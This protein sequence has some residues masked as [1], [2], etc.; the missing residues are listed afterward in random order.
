[1][2]IAALLTV[3]GITPLPNS[4]AHNDYVHA[5]PL[6]DAL[7]A[8]FCSI[9]ADIFLQD[10]KLL[11]G[12]S[13]KELDA[14]R[15]LESLY[16]GPLAQRARSN[17]GWIY[18]PD[19]PVQLLI[20]IKADGEA[21]YE[22]LRPMLERYSA[23]LTRWDGERLVPSAV[24]VVISGDRPFEKIAKSS[25]RYCAIDGRA[26]DL[27]QNPSPRLV[28]LISENWLGQFKW[29]GVRSMPSDQR[30]RLREFVAKAH[31]QGRKVRFWATP[32]TP[33][34]WKELWAAKVDYIGADRFDDLRRFLLEQRPRP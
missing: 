26:I 3:V 13:R 24:S 20:D 31:G 6:L 22:V 4:H 15:T 16:L 29:L 33:D 9:E 18:R 30:T 12:H 14:E 17:G 10:G 19:L 32:E 34:L 28:P 1:M 2:I 11:V 27:E 21:A 5:R 25:P 7:D 8:G 23:F